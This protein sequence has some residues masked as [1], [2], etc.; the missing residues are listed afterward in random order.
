MPIEAVK[1]PQ[2]VQIED[3]IIGPLSLRQ[4][5][6]MT[7]GGGV[8]YVLYSAVA[9]T[10]G[11]HASIA[12]TVI[13]WTPAVIAAL[14]AIIKINDLS[15]MR[16]CFLTIERMSKAPIRTWAPRRGLTIT[17]HTSAKEDELSESKKKRKEEEVLETAKKVRDIG[18]ISSVLD[19]PLEEETETP[20]KTVAS[21]PS[22]TPS[23]P[24]DPDHIAVDQD[25]EKKPDDGLS[26]YRGVFRDIS[27]ST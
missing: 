6:I 18:K 26:A 12:A 19:Q 2:N 16:I 8:S 13:C 25:V 17:I 14:F 11:G 21:A 9:K 22:A 27:P 23:L 24:V 4:I 1:I 5:I 10:G 3:R 20:E 7:L 15:L